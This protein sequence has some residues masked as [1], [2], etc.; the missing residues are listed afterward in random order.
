MP[1]AIGVAL[2]LVLS[3]C[4]ASIQRTIREPK[5]PLTVA[6]VVV[7]PVRFTGGTQPPWRTWE[8]SER[9]IS[10]GLMAAGSQLALFGPSEF[11][12]KRWEDEGAWVAST[13]VPLLVKSGVLPE[14][15]LVLRATA[16][17]RVGSQ[18]QEARDAKGRAR[19]GSTSE[20]TTWVC[21]VEVLH[22]SSGQVLA[23]LT[24]QVT[25]DPFAEPGPE[26]EFDPD[27]PMTHLI[28]R[29]TTEAFELAL[30]YAVQ[31]EHPKDLPVT[32][33]ESPAMTAS[34][35]DPEVAK[36]DPLGAELWLQ[37]RARY[38]S[39]W[40]PDAQ[41]GKLARLGVGL[42]VTATKGSAG[43]EPGD[44]LVQVDGLAPQAQILARKRLDLTPVSVRVRR[45]GT[46]AEVDTI[47]P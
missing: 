28:E 11:Q 13:A 3:A 14:R 43:V 46:G 30:K 42:W 38:L 4:S 5:E 33:A 22:P 19:A 1:R 12:I 31:R 37:N 16:E 47:I 9:V 36:L 17:R 34:F 25:I 8:L 29:L 20:E 39:P 7:Y 26:A 21:S 44:L 23:E 2:G 32:L 10:A 15:A 45:G 35:P 24:A 41:A 40:L 27:A 18:S 6:A